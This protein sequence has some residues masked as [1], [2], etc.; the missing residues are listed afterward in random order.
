MHLTKEQISEA[1]KTF[2]QCWNSVIDAY[3][4]QLDEVKWLRN[5]IKLCEE[6]S[7]GK[8]QKIKQL[9]RRVVELTEQ[10][11]KVCNECKE[12]MKRENTSAV[13]VQETGSNSGVIIKILEN[14]EHKTESTR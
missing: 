12:K 1:R 9:E 6:E 11:A 8:S 4:G 5:E 3:E 10:L 2:C 13:C 14:L 7:R